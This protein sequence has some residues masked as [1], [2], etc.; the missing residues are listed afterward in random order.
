MPDA[1]ENSVS[2]TTPRARRSLAPG[3]DQVPHGRTPPQTSSAT[4]GYALPKVDG[5]ACREIHPV[6]GYFSQFLSKAGAT[7]LTMA[8]KRPQGRW[9][10]GG[11]GRHVQQYRLTGESVDNKLAVVAHYK[12]CKEIRKTIEH[13]FPNLSSRSNDSKRTTIL[14]WARESK[15]L[16][17]AAAEGK[18]THKKVR[19]VGTANVMSAENEAYLAQWVN[20]LREEGIP[21]STRMLKDKALD[22]AEEAELPGFKASDKWVIMGSKTVTDLAFVVLRDRAK[23]APPTST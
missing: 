4:D 17:A 7:S 12:Q 1:E 15:R 9:S 14:R 3:R 18:G 21:V 20:E 23:S 6:F 16:Y 19:S 22:V 11:T 8:H 2:P 10:L 5:I 13:Y